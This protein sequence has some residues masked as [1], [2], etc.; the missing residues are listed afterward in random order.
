MPLPAPAECCASPLPGRLAEATLEEP[1]AMTVPMASAARRAG[2]LIGWPASLVIMGL[3]CHDSAGLGA[4][5]VI[6]KD[7]PAV[8][9]RGVGAPV[10]VYDARKPI[11]TAATGSS[12]TVQPMAQGIT[13]RKP[14]PQRYSVQI[15]A[16]PLPPPPPGA[17]PGMAFGPPVGIPN[18]AVEAVIRPGQDQAITSYICHDSAVGI[19]LITLTD[20]A[21]RVS[22]QIVATG[23]GDDVIS[24]RVLEDTGATVRDPTTR[25]HFSS[26][27]Y[28]TANQ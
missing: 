15:A 17:L 10:P 1:P 21:G 14:S 6:T 2:H 26:F 20:N 11:P 9:L 28:E 18:V 23:D 12:I 16:L 27:A 13:I 19:A 5:I 22:F 8:N 25:W 7:M 24:I 3:V 4:G